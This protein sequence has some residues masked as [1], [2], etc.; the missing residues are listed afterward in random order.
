[1][2]G[3]R[4]KCEQFV[5]PCYNT[6]MLRR[7]Y[8]HTLKPINGRDMWESATGEEVGAPPFPPKKKSNYQF[9]RKLEENEKAY[10]FGN[11]YRDGSKIHCSNYGQARHN[12][13][14]CSKRIKKLKALLYTFVVLL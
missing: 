13:K 10:K 12:K 6:E 2:R 9:R 8:S 5:H 11:V 1:M 7:T 14:T 3:E 4:L